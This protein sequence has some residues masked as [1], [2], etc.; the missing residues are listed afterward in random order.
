MSKKNSIEAKKRF[1]EDW[2]LGLFDRED[3][4][5]TWQEFRHLY[6]KENKE[7]EKRYK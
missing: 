5:E 2:K 6:L 4:E 7:L 3:K 1:N